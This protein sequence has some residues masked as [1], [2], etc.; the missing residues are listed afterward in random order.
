LSTWMMISEDNHKGRLSKTTICLG[1]RCSL[2]S[3]LVLWLFFVSGLALDLE[4]WLLLI[5]FHELGKIELGF[6]E[7]L[8]LSDEDVL[9]GEDLNAL[10]NDLLAN[11]I[12]DEFLGKLLESGL[13]GLIDHN[14]HHLLTDELALRSL[15]VACG[16]HLTAGSLGEANAEHTEEVSVGSLGLDEGLNGGVPFLDDGAE[17]VTGDVHSIKVG[18]AIEALD[19]FDL[20]LHLSPSLFV[21]ISVQISQRYLKHTA[22]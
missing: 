3:E 18:V 15:G 16:A 13:L 19:L 21:A 5:E 17:L 2:G 20:N 6:L 9:E 22:L 8:N 1:F 12:L 4:L 7:K 14:L 11:S 10:L